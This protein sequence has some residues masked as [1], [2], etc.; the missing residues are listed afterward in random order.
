MKL[1][2]KQHYVERIRF[3][4]Y[5]PHSSQGK[6]YLKMIQKEEWVRK[7]SMID[8]CPFNFVTFCYN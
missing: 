6:N 1:K 7:L 8:Q 3:I 4:K 5:G 2:A